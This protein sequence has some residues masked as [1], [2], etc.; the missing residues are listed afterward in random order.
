MTAKASISRKDNHLT[1]SGDLNFA[2]VVHLW[3]SSTALMNSG[4]AT[5][6]FDLSGVTSANSAGLALLLEWLKYAKQKNKSI[7]FDQIPE[8][9]LSIAKVSG[10]AEMLR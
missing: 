2:T 7:E 10:I 8:Q 9:L 6:Y 4:S 5:L 1:V 3:K